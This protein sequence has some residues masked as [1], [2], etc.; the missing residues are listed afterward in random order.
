MSPS[1]CIASL[2]LYSVAFVQCR[3]TSCVSCPLSVLCH[4]C[5]VSPS[6]CI[7]S[8]PLCI[9]SPSFCVVLPPMYHIP[10]LYDAPFL[11][12]CLL[13]ASCHHLSVL[14]CL[15]MSSP[16]CIISPF[17]GCASCYLVGVLCPL[18]SVITSSVIYAT[19][20]ILCHLLS[21]SC[22]YCASTFLC[23]VTILSVS[24]HHSV[25]SPF[26]VTPPYLSVSFTLLCNVTFL[27]VPCCVVSP[28]CHTM[29]PFCI[30]YL[31]VLCCLSVTSH[32]CVMLP[33]CIA[34]PYLSWGVQ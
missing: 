11:L 32:M 2:P 19:S 21:A 16:F 29:L 24:C 9:L 14:W 23:H 31:T 5:F 27:Y 34:P 20:F 33:F 30:I 10:F 26:C 1:V 18:L 4:F 3:V 22:L 15:L 25:T 13:S 8:S 28:F 12:C 17:L 7:T 6:V